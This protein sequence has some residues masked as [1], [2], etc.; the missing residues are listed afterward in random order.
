[1]QALR[2]NKT[3]ATM[4]IIQALRTMHWT[5]WGMLATVILVAGIAFVPEL[6]KFMA[7]WKY[8]FG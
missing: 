6:I 8:V 5:A 7:F 4:K 2:E 1:L 3:G